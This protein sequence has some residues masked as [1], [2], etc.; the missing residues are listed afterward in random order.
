M[1]WCIIA[2]LILI[3]LGIA[4]LVI[5][6]I[7]KSNLFGGHFFSNV[8]KVMLFISNTQLYIPVNL[9]EIAGS[10]HIFKIRGK[11]TT[12]CITFKKNGIWDVLQIDWKEIIVTLNGNEVN[13]PTS[14]ILPFRHRFSARKLVRK[15]PLLL[16]VVLRQGKT[17][18]TL[19]NDNR[20]QNTTT[21]DA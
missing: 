1:Q 14:V 9:C 13:L 11:L 8:T 16:H 20:N 3:L 4:I 18:Y 2:L 6:K 5:G 21:N 19:E 15:Q 17:W 10:I 12:E 7:K